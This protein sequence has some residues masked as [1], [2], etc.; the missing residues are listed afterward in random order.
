M[1]MQDHIHRGPTLGYTLIFSCVEGLHP[2][3]ALFKGDLH[4]AAFPGKAHRGKG[5]HDFHRQKEKKAVKDVILSQV[6]HGTLYVL[7]CCVTKLPQATIS[8]YHLLE[9]K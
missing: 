3:P 7:Y 6:L 2:N 8:I 4:W 9:F 5:K 1:E